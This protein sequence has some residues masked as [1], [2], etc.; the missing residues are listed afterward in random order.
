MSAEQIDIFSRRSR[1]EIAQ[2]AKYIRRK[3]AMPIAMNSP[4]RA[5]EPPQTVSHRRRFCRVI[6]IGTEPIP[7]TQSMCDLFD[8]VFFFDEFHFDKTCH[9]Y[10]PQTCY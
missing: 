8:V 10:E 5:P 7:S 3:R 9:I 1:F 6:A 2:H 4:S